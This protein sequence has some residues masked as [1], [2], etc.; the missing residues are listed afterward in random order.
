MRNLKILAAW[1]AANAGV[2]VETYN[3]STACISSGKNGKKVIKLPASWVLSTDPESESLIQG[4][5]DHEA[6][7]HGRYTDFDAK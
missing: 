4:V 1:L 3:G 7:G 2:D 5:I 6:L